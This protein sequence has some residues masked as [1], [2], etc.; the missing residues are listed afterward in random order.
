MKVTLYGFFSKQNMHGG[1]F[2]QFDF[3]KGK[4]YY[5]CF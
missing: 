5:K 4:K 1:H 3:I 2:N